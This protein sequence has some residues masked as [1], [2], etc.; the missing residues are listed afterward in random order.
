MQKGENKMKR[1]EAMK[2]VE[3]A[4]Q[5]N[6]MQ[7]RQQR[8]S[9]NLPTAFV[10]YSGHVAGL[11]VV[12]HETGWRQYERPDRKFEFYTDEPLNKEYFKAYQR[13]MLGLIQKN[14]P[15]SGHSTGSG[16]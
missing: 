4:M 2:I 6:S 3:L 13:Y 8:C 14:D 15:M 7:E 10:R 5:V 16:E 9:G 1:K 11:D 12:V